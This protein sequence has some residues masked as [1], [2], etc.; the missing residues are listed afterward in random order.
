ML[1]WVGMMSHIFACFS[2]R[3]NSPE[4]NA[5]TKSEMAAGA[6][7]QTPGSIFE[8][9]D[10]YSRL[11]AD[12]RLHAS[13]LAVQDRAKRDSAA[14]SEIAVASDQKGSHREPSKHSAAPPR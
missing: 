12:C 13:V 1:I 6:G 14:L 4:E 8:L 3:N 10:H 5:I 2:W 11:S 7:V 9:L